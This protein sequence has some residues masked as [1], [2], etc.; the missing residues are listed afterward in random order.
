MTAFRLP[1]VSRIDL[2][3]ALMVL[4]WAANYSLVKQAFREIAP[5]PFNVARFSL[6]SAAFLIG[7]AW[8]RH[9]ARRSQA[10]NSA[11]YTAH[12][13][14][15]ADWRQ[16][17]WLGLVGHCAYHLLWATGLSMTTASNSALLVGAGPVVVSTTAAWLGHERIRR[18]HWYGIVVSLAGVVLVVGRG[19]S[20]AGP[21]IWGDLLTLSAIGCWTFLTIGGSRLMTRHSPLYVSG[22]VTTIGTLAYIVLALPSLGSVGWLS[23][24]PRVWGVIVF[25]GLLSVAAASVIWYAAV[26]QIGV[27]R[28]SAYSNLVPLVAVLIAAYVIPEPLTSTKIIGAA[29]VLAGVVLTRLAR[30]APAAP[31]E[32]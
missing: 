32:E 26:R 14:T 12:P 29:L 6:A 1:R 24:G 23:L 7:I 18:A 31:I 22:V 16:F 25:S 13:P 11:F 30:T 10:V 3:L 2:L 28:T 20:I 4:V 9:R 17:I 15:A 19:A 5:M 8:V 27:A 21:T